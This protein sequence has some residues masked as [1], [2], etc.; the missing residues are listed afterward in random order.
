MTN[1]YKTAAQR[2]AG[3]V[4]LRRVNEN[5][6]IERAVNDMDWGGWDGEQYIEGAQ[7]QLGIDDEKDPEVV[8]LARELAAEELGIRY[9]DAYQTFFAMPQRIT[10]WREIRVPWAGSVEATIRNIKFRNVGIYWS[11]EKN[12]ADVHWGDGDGVEA[13]LEGQVTRTAVDWE[14]TLALNLSPSMGEDEKELRLF[15][16]APVRVTAVTIGGQ[17]VRVNQMATA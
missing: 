5:T 1:W 12:A 16:N 11:Y 14:S 2:P 10:V 13:L 9:A 8:A 4:G 6:V 7:R 15:Q 17:S 3:Y